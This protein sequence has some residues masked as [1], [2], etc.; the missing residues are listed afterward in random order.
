[1]LQGG[2]SVLPLGRR[3]GGGRVACGA[4]RGCRAATALPRAGRAPLEGGIALNLRGGCS[5][6]RAFGQTSA[7]VC[8]L[9]QGP[10]QLLRCVAESSLPG[11]ATPCWWRRRGGTTPLL[12]H[13]P[14]CLS[15][16]T[17][18]SPDP[19]ACR[20]GVGS[21]VATS[22]S[23]CFPWLS[24]F[25]QTAVLVSAL[26][27]PGSRSGLCRRLGRAVGRGGWLGWQV[28]AGGAA[29]WG[30]GSVTAVGPLALQRKLLRVVPVQRHWLLRQRRRERRAEPAE[31]S[32]YLWWHKACSYGGK[33]AN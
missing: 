15:F 16:A 26:V 32:G 31:T 14:P 27:S 21:E 12:Q 17:S 2:W 13:L 7:K 11:A 8:P 25:L 9:W 6:P 22:S 10:E 4:A 5:V 23:W 29:A 28:S 3:R 24:M 19:V 20:G 33:G 30:G 1:V 18:P